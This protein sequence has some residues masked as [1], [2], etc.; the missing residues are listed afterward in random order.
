MKRRFFIIAL[1]AVLTMIS[2]GYADA[3]ITS[4]SVTP[5]TRAF[6]TAR[7]TPVN[8]TWSIRTMGGLSVTVESNTGE[9]LV[10]GAQARPTNVLPSQTKTSIVP[11]NAFFFTFTE[12][13]NIPADVIRASQERGLPLVYRRRFSDD[14][15][16][17]NQELSI[18]MS[19]TSPSIAGPLEVTRM[20]L[21]SDNG[22]PVCS[23]RT[24]DDLTVKAFVDTDGTGTL[25]GNWQVRDSLESGNFR[26]LRTINVPV[27]G[28]RNI[29]LRSPPIPT[30]GTS[31]VDV[32]LQITTP[33]PTFTE[34]FIACTIAGSD[35]VLN[36]YH[37][38]GKET[39]VVAPTAF[40]P[41]SADTRIEWRAVEGT[42]AYRI[43][44]LAEPDTRPV[45]AQQAKAG[46]TSATLSP[47]TLA[48]LNAGRR[49]M[50]RVYSE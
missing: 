31:R 30:N 23:A 7:V 20:R 44:I 15:F 1:M 5:Q 28:G 38:Q 34:P 33:A 27:S 45:A 42:R 43:E 21:A 6:T 26:T 9:Y 35:T 47:L 11:P 40:M 46:D 36:A 17:T 22:A 3:A 16:A 24:G 12:T 41:L 2:A 10:G 48:K 8:I 39:E 19:F 37:P 14:G 50:V 13:I 49:Y 32:R 4:G 25:R 29:E 18:S